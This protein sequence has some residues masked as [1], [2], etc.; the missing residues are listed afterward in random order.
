MERLLP[1]R[2]SSTAT[3]IRGLEADDGFLSE[4]RR[5]TRWSLHSVFRRTINI[6]STDDVLLT[7]ANRAGTRAPYTLVCSAAVLDDLGIAAGDAVHADQDVLRLG[8]RMTISLPGLQITSSVIRSRPV[9]REKLARTVPVIEGVLAVGHRPGSFF[10]AE[11]AS[12]FDRELQRRLRAGGQALRQSFIAGETTGVAT[13]CRS[14]L[15]LGIGLTPSGDDYLVGF[16]GAQLACRPT[17]SQPTAAVRELIQAVQTSAR[18]ATNA[19]SAA[20]VMAA[21]GCRVRQ[22]V[23]D[24]IDSALSGEAAALRTALRTL[25]DIGS[26]SGTDITVGVVDSL[27]VLLELEEF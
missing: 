12:P 1:G 16:L 15:G 20:A 4:I 18:T 17:G 9:D 7:V 22:E 6:V 23:S 14:L 25:V 8:D 5:S 10:S 24:V 13:A 2:A 3:V 11:D 27:S 21:A 26:T 19:I